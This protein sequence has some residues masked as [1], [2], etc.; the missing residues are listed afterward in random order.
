MFSR[1][2]RA[3]RSRR[4]RERGRDEDGHG[5]ERRGGLPQASSPASGAFRT[6]QMCS[7]GNAR[8]HSSG[9]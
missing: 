7:P 3:L 8:A 2:S 5:E 6:F 4:R 9:A 1:S